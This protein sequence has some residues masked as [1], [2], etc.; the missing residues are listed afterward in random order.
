M[1]AA[2]KTFF[3][4]PRFAVVGASQDTSKYGY[5]GHIATFP[6]PQLA[7]LIPLC[8]PSMVSQTFATSDTS[9]PSHITDLTSFPDLPYRA[10]R[11]GAAITCGDVR[12]HHH[13]SGGDTEG[14]EGSQRGRS[15][16]CLVAAGELR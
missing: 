5:K 1:E 6:I 16:S 11:F 3:T 8:S 4:S 13:T 9:Q 2:L 15:A 14:V 10:V 7:K 12:L